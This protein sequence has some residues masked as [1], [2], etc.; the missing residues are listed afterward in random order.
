MR[1]TSSIGTCGIE[2]QQCMSGRCGIQHDELLVYLANH[3]R[4]RLEDRDFFCTD[5]A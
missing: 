3:V 1:T 2:Q 4:K 5:R